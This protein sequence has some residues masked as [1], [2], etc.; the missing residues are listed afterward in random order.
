MA[1]LKTSLELASNGSS[2]F[3]TAAEPYQMVDRGM[4]YGW[5]NTLIAAATPT[6]ERES[7]PLVDY[8]FHRVITSIGRRTIYSIAR[9]LYWSVGPLKAS[10]DE[11]ANLSTSPLT[12]RFGGKNKAWGEQATEWLDNWHKVMCLERWPYDYE[13]YTHLLGSGTIMDGEVHTLLSEDSGGNPRVQLIPTHRIGSRYQTGGVCKVTYDQNSLYIDDILV[14]GTLPWT[15]KT[16]VEFD[17]PVVDGVIVDAQGGP[18][19]YR[20]FSDPAVSGAYRDIGARSLFPSF[21]PDVV[22][23]LHGI[24]SLGSSVFQWQDWN[25]FRR[26]E[27]LAQK[28]FSSRTLMEHNETGEADSAK[29]LLTSPATFNT[30]GTK[31][32]LDVQKLQGGTIQYFRAKSG[33]KL[34]AFNWSDR[35]GRN[36]QDFQETTLRDAM[37][38]SGWDMFFSLDPKSVGGAPMRV[39]VDRVNRQIKKCRRGVVKSLYRA[40]MYAIAKAIKRGDLPFDPDCFK[41]SYQGAPDVTADRRYDAETDA[42][43]YELGWGTLKDICDKRKSD[44]NLTRMQREAEVDDLYTRAR[45]ISD[46]HGIPIQEAVAQLSKMGNAFINIG[47]NVPDNDT[48]DGQ[49]PAAK[50]PAAPA[51]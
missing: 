45:R 38:G 43:E 15:F 26:F 13:T 33:S 22:G 48:K 1:A 39:V 11:Q 12:Q 18:I 5:S 50:K 25:E 9:T 36:A 6:D 37:R 32:T 42:Q 35:P 21:F 47:E 27:M 2:R 34:E 20:V 24:S 4:N 49:A 17:A 31:S 3:K 8:D 14:D 10:V 28:A 51:A 23:Q 29:A 44:W 40:D 46:K 19:A 41:W 16:K 7:K 30:D